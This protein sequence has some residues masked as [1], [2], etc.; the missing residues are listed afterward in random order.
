ML[1]YISQIH[2]L[3]HMHTNIIQYI[4]QYVNENEK[5][6]GLS[7]GIPTNE[8]KFLNHIANFIGDSLYQ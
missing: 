5:K 2:S 7:Q 4:D 3:Q 6:K 1:K 8:I